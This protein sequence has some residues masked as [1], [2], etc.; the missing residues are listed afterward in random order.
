M[1]Y[2]RKKRQQATSLLL[3]SK[4]SIKLYSSHR[5]FSPKPISFHLCKTNPPPKTSPQS[6]LSSSMATTT[7]LKLVLVFLFVFFALSSEAARPLGME[8]V[9]LMGVERVPSLEPDF[10]LNSL[11]PKGSI[12]PSGP[13]KKVNSM[14]SGER[15]FAMHTKNINRILN[16]VPSPSVGN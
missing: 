14:V 13:S 15:L 10:V 4:P 11:L 2:R 1:K 16:S 9:A 6:L 8:K 5:I 3:L 7:S 12:P